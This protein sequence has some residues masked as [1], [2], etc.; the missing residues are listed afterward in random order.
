MLPASCYKGAMGIAYHQVQSDLLKVVAA[1]QTLDSGQ[2]NLKATKNLCVKIENGLGHII[3]VENQFNS[4]LASYQTASDW[5]GWIEGGLSVVV[6][7]VA[8][9]VGA[10][11]VGAPLILHGVDQIANSS[12]NAIYGNS[13][14]QEAASLQQLITNFSIEVEAQQC[15]NNFLAERGSL[16]TAMTNIQ[17]AVTDL[18]TQQVVLQNLA[19]QNRQALQEGISVLSQEQ[20]S[21][22]EQSRASVLGRREGDAVQQG[23][24]LEPPAAVP[25]DARHR[26]RVPAV[27]AVPIADC[28]GEDAG[29]APGGRDRPPG[30]AGVA[31]DQ[32][33]PAQ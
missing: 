13:L 30:G 12:I 3:N 31:H 33:A 18:G 25:R 26:V 17:I 8:C 6:G 27:I 19:I 24:R 29:A 15:W 20:E 7:A 21:P 5:A 11:A 2:A 28:V 32:P 23:V 10:C 22:G 9:Y 14:Q 4:M 1:R 16:V